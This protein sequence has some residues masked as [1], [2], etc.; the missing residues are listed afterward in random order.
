MSSGYVVSSCFMGKRHP[1]STDVTKI[2]GPLT[3]SAVEWSVV[4][5][6]HNLALGDESG[7]PRIV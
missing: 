1:S 7:M 3:S 6:A 2:E 5:L 4:V